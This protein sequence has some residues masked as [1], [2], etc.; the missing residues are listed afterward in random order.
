M[1]GLL[2]HAY[3]NYA[4][5]ADSSSSSGEH[6]RDFWCLKKGLHWTKLL[7]VSSWVLPVGFSVGTESLNSDAYST[8]V[9]IFASTCTKIFI[10]SLTVKFIL[11][12]N[13]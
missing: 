11:V 7:L 5:S 2:S 1:E 9:P 12:C 13:F 4:A 10:L 6:F 8:C 3:L